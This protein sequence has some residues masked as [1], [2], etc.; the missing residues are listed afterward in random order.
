[1][2]LTPYLTAA[3]MLLGILV[4]TLISPRINQQVNTQYNKKSL[5]FQKKLEYFEK[6]TETIEQNKKL[7]SQITGK[8]ESSK[9]NKEIEK[10][11]NELKKNRQ[12]FMVMS[13]PLYFHTR[14]LKNFSEKITHFVR[15]EKQF[16]NELSEMKEKDKWKKEE[17]IERFREGQKKLNKIGNDIILDMKRGLSE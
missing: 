4:G 3:I 2:D 9:N 6:I 15:I 8:I 11:I 1:M 14:E 17:L 13:S 5:I 10:I 16:F 7:Y 12:N